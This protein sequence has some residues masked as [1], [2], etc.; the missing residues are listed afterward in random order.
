M[1]N[2]WYTKVDSFQYLSYQ[3]LCKMQK[4]GQPKVDL[5]NVSFYN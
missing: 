1:K 3:L 4:K 5:Y 2:I